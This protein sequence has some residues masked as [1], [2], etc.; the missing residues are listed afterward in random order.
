G[1]N[2]SLDA[3]SVVVFKQGTAINIKTPGAVMS[4]VAIYDTRGRQV[5]QRGGINAPE[6]VISGLQVEQ[7]VLI[8]EIATE[9]G[10]VSKRIVF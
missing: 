7:Q 6:T 3:Q 8:L 9:K 4:S 2:P 10:S 5:Y 1:N